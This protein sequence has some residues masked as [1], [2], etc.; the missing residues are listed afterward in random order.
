VSFKA[1]RHP[2][3]HTALALPFFSRC[4]ARSGRQG[5]KGR[6][7]RESTGTRRMPASLFL[8]VPAGMAGAAQAAIPAPGSKPRGRSSRPLQ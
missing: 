8:E 3:S 5:I 7:L 4:R 6:P 1:N 2:S